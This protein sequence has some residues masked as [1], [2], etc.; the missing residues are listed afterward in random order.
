MGF[1]LFASLVVALVAGGVLRFLHVVRGHLPGW[2]Y[3]PLNLG[4]WFVLVL[5]V[6]HV[7]AL[8]A[9]FLF[10]PA[11]FLMLLEP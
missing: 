4:V 3:W 5:A 9:L 10:G 8:L 6:Y 11:A 1:V 7:L 2:V